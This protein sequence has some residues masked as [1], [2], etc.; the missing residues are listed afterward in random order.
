MASV[1]WLQRIIVTREPFAGYYQSID[2]TFWERTNGDLP[3]LKPLADL[4]I[5]AE[6]ARPESG[7]SVP[8]NSVYRIHGAA[9][10]SDAEI[11]KVEVSTDSGKLWNPAK[12]GRDSVK[13]SWRLWEHEWRTPA[14]PG[15]RT[16][17]ARATD[18]LG[19]TQSSERD[20]DRGT[21]MINHLL[22]IV[23]EIR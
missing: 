16:L 20:N 14:D 10:S 8:A 4:Q 3:T 22:P 13:N 2:Y 1:K 17:M 7:E 18:S 19:R 21:Y 9:W 15:R 11:T 5:K 12:L 23:V 6:I